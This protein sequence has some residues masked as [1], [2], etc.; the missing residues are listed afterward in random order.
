MPVAQAGDTTSRENEVEIRRQRNNRPVP[1]NP[2]RQPT[3]RRPIMPTKCQRTTNSSSSSNI[4]GVV[5][6]ERE[7][8]VDQIIKS[9]AD[10]RHRRGEVM[11]NIFG[12]DGV[13]KMANLLNLPPLSF[14]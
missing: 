4:T 2:L 3:L 9:L 7:E 5:V 12:N 14:R 8:I 10:H 1:V 6:V 13:L 11:V